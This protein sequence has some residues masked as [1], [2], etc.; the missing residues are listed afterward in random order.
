MTDRV[1]D[2][3]PRR[4]TQSPLHAVGIR[5]LKQN[6]SEIIARA[7]NGVRF[8]VLSN[9]KPVGVVIQRAAAIRSRWVSTDALVAMSEQLMTAQAEPGATGGASPSND[10]TNWAE[11]RRVQRGLELDLI[12]DPWTPWEP[13][14]SHPRSSVDRDSP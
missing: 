4:T 10:A 14:E 2:M 11:E 5:E 3:E 13:H 1:D 7:A 6:P 8:E 9:G 12:V